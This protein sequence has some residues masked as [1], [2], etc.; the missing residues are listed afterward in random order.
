MKRIHLFEFTDLAWYPQTFRRIQTDYLQFATTLGSGHKNLIPLFAKAMQHA[1]T[2]EIVDLC[3]GGSGPWIRLQEEFKAAGL[4]VSIKM[5][6]K[7][8]NPQALQR[9]SV[10]SRQGIEY[11]DEPVDATNVPTHLNGMRTLFEGF[12][13][14]KPEQAK[15]ILQDALEKRSALGIFEAS[16][17]VPFGFILLVVSPLI[18]LLSYILLTP[19]STPRTLSRFVWTYLIPVVPLV[20]CWDGI[21][22]MLRVYSIKEL[23]QLTNSLQSK[24]YVWEVGQA[25]TGTPVFVFTYLLGY[26]V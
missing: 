24:E 4:K 2:T 16:F 9:W 15:I 11:L 20:T 25:S 6:D 23:K 5:T 26:P 8:P 1:R 21:V 19:F 22:S 3:S 14:F 17:K 12:H 7:F 18:T 13:H 10:A